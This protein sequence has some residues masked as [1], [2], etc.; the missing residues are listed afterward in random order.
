M[1]ITSYIASGILEAYVLGEVSPQEAREVSCLSSIYPE[2]QTE[3]ESLQAGL[4][5]LASSF[6]KTPPPALKASILAALDAIEDEDE[7]PIAMAPQVSEHIGEK[8]DESAVVK[9]MFSRWYVQAAAAVALL[10]GGLYLGQQM[11]NGQIEGMENE[12]ASLQ[13]GQNTLQEQLDAR[14]SDIALLTKP[15]SKIIDLAPQPKANGAT[16]KVLWQPETGESYFLA[17]TLPAPPSDKD[18]QL[19]ALIEGK[20]VDLG[21]IP[22][23]ANG[24]IKMKG[25]GRA[26]AFAVTLEPKGGSVNPT[27]ADLLVLGE[28]G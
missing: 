7:T 20:P 28:V 12:I 19:W 10:L 17:T 2:I 8:A 14:S 24:I 13:Q 11:M 15:S 26:D 22:R 4:E 25:T 3:L 23:D 1:D 27:L 18:Y 21:V 5:G 6:E 16:M 9:P